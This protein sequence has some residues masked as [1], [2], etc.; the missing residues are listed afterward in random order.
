MG[1]GQWARAG[2]VQRLAGPGPAGLV[3][4]VLCREVPGLAWAKQPLSVGP[5]P[6][7][8][9][10]SQVTD[11]RH[12]E[13]RMMT[14]WWQWWLT[15]M[16]HE[17]GHA[18]PPVPAPAP[19]DCE[20]GPALTRAHTKS[21]DLGAPDRNLVQSRSPSREE[22]FL[23]DCSHYQSI[24]SLAMPRTEHRMSRARPVSESGWV[25]LVWTD[26]SISAPHTRDDNKHGPN[27][28]CWCSSFSHSFRYPLTLWSCIDIYASVSI[29][30]SRLK[31][32]C[33]LDWAFA[34][35]S[36][37]KEKSTQKLQYLGHIPHLPHPQHMYLK[38]TF[39]QAKIEAQLKATYFV[40]KPF[41]NSQP[42]NHERTG[43][44]KGI[45]TE[46]HLNAMN[47]K[48]ICF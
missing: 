33:P 31:T 30:I 24:R 14:R 43:Q 8:R 26:H 44:R 42:F 40:L 17:W 34:N 27:H 28:C 29:F 32:Y 47:W 25:W 45:L 48:R 16:S 10:Q 12:E 41:E 7:V 1:G 13:D 19:A 46:L 4:S 36:Q 39:G 21:W 3:S 37:G 20:P 38:P 15:V 5:R 9:H 18:P 11:T 6:S 23:K 35:H 22:I 2:M